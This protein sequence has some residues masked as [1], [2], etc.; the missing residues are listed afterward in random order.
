MSLTRKAANLRI[1]FI[2]VLVF[3]SPFC[4]QTLFGEENPTEPISDEESFLAAEPVPDEEASPAAEILPDEETSLAAEPI[5]DEETSLAAEPI[6]DDEFFLDDEAFFFDAPTLVFEAAPF[7]GTRSFNEIFTNF[8]PSQ[9]IMAMSETGLRYAFEKDDTPSLIPDP[10]SGIDLL[11]SVMAKKPSHIVEA[12]VVV[13]Y[14]KKELDMLDVYNALGRIKNIKDHTVSLNG[15]D[16]NIFTDTT[17]LESA[18]NRKPIPDPSPADTLPFS[19]TMYILFLD[20]Y[21][22]DLYLRGDISMSLYGLTYSMTNFRDVRYSIFKI[23]K[24]ERFS[25]ILYIEPIKEG[26]LIYSVS[27]LY[28]PNFIAKRVNLT[29]NMNRRITVLLNWITDGL[30]IQESEWLSKRIKR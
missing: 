13:P 17:R 16:I 2:F 11:S 28:L 10:D 3:I 1:L 27:G 6:P 26:I 14:D 24:T 7:S 25:A 30:R 23:M 18:K 20:P 15:R 12:L 9:K 5:P 4:V 29:P 22:G 19:E 8:S 21:L